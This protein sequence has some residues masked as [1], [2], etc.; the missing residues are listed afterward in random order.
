VSSR[1]NPLGKPTAVDYVVMIGGPICFLAI[2]IWGLLWLLGPAPPEN[3]VSLLKQGAVKPGMTREQVLDQV[4]APKDLETRP[5]GGFAF[6]YHRGTEEPFV[7]EDAVVTFSP[8][9]LVTRVSFERSAVPIQG[10]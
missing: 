9:G 8:S 10:E 4:G 2:A 5:D 7:E 3:P 1:P 6:I